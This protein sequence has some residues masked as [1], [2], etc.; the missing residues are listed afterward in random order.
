MK[1][2]DRLTPPFS[3]YIE[4]KE[5]ETKAIGENLNYAEAIQLR[6]SWKDEL[7]K[8][9]YQLGFNTNRLKKGSL[10]QDCYIVDAVGRKLR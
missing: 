9:G 10:W 2:K 3:V 6:F 4:G 5:I 7:I 8:D 1:K